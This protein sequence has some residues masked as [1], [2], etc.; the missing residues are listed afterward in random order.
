MVTDVAWFACV[1]SA[2]RNRQGIVFEDIREI[3]RLY[4][5][6]NGQGRGY[7]ARMNGWPFHE[8]KRQIEYKAA[9]AGVPVI[10]L[11]R[12]ETGGDR[13]Y[14]GRVTDSSAFNQAIR[15]RARHTDD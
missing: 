12:S 13:S 6:G 2:L 7:R 5:R 15:T 9:W 11:S 14:G 1:E 10:T 8:I 3:R 4:G